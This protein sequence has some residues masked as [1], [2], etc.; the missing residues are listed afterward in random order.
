MPRGPEYY[1]GKAAAAKEHKPLVDAAVALR[2]TITSDHCGTDQ[3]R[4]AVLKLV[5]ALNDMES[6]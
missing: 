1:V 5:D 6:S 3:L 2:E 4:A